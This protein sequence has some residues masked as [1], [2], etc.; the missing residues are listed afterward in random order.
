MHFSSY[1]LPGEI[2]LFAS[3]LWCPYIFLVV[4]NAEWWVQELAQRGVQ[5]LFDKGRRGGWIISSDSPEVLKWESCD[6]KGRSWELGRGCSW[7]VCPYRRG[8]AQGLVI[9]VA[10]M[11]RV[12]PSL[13]GSPDFCGTAWTPSL[14]VGWVINF[15]HILIS[16]QTEGANYRED[17]SGGAK[18]QVLLPWYSG[19][20]NERLHL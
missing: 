9:P 18:H 1:T 15:I 19:L 17:S 4:Y 16:H 2:R 13:R 3:F 8:L 11:A 12:A 5:R 6:L 7:P 14:G 10:A 20:P